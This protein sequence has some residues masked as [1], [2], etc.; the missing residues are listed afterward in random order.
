[1]GVKFCCDEL[2]T[3]ENDS[4]SAFRKTLNGENPEKGCFQVVDK[5]VFEKRRK[6]QLRISSFL[7]TAP[8][9]R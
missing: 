9:G 5:P 4:N 3:Y 7:L 8:S 6:N 1:M 2:K